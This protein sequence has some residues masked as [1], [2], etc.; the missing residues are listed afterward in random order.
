M[1]YSLFHI[2]CNLH[3][4]IPL[5][6]TVNSLIISM[7]WVRKWGP[8]RLN[9]LPKGTLLVGEGATVWLQSQCTSLLPYSTWFNPSFEILHQRSLMKVQ[10]NSNWPESRMKG[11]ACTSSQ[12]GINLIFSLQIHF[13]GIAKIRMSESQTHVI[14][15]VLRLKLSLTPWSLI[16]L[17]SLFLCLILSHPLPFT[18][19]FSIT[20]QQLWGIYFI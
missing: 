4:L 20:E 5:I 8:E 15:C 19:P 2:L 9:D 11:K 18:S 17:I 14:F 1:C 13:L 16:V 3:I 10:S 6:L 7:V 12:L